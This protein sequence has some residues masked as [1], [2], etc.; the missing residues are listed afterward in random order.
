MYGSTKWPASWRKLSTAS[1]GQ[2]RA[3]TCARLQRSDLSPSAHPLPFQAFGRICRRVRYHRSRRDIMGFSW[4]FLIVAG[5]VLA[6]S[7][8]HAQAST[9]IGTLACDVSKGIGM[10]VVQKQTLSCVF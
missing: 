10:F 9:Q 3:G 7:G 1:P 5:F 8:A 4:H 2:A 6:A